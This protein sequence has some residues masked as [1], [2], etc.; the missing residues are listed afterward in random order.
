MVEWAGFNSTTRGRRHFSPGF[1]LY[2]RRI[3]YSKYFIRI[4]HKDK[5]TN[6]PNWLMV[7]VNE[8]IL[9][10][11]LQSYSSN[12]YFVENKIRYFLITLMVREC[13]KIYLLI[14]SIRIITTKTVRIFFGFWYG[15][16]GINSANTSF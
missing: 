11:A 12:Y 5:G 6:S 4:S 8:G 10:K 7:V 16:Y 13:F 1:I 3:H 14:Y 9:I 15:L 2:L